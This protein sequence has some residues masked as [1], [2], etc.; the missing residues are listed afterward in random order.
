MLCS[1]DIR[2]RME[3]G[4]K[5]KKARELQCASWSL[6]GSSVCTSRAWAGVS[7]KP[8]GAAGGGPAGPPQPNAGPQNM[9]VVCH[10]SHRGVF[11]ALLR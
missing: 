6:Y 7:M 9:V 4:G 8:G 1:G 3:S 11:R 5:E 2:A 10:C